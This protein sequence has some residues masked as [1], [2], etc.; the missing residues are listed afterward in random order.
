MAVRIWTVVDQFRRICVGILGRG[1][2][3]HSAET[4]KV[5]WSMITF[6]R[7]YLWGSN[8]NP[9]DPGFILDAEQ[10][11]GKPYMTRVERENTRLRHYV[12]LLIPYLNLGDV[13]VSA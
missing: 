1:I 10:I 3:D 12:Q 8:G 13:P 2:S 4:F 5:P 7:F 11:V 9:V 6:W